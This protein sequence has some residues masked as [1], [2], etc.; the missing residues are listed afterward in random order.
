MVIIIVIKRVCRN[1]KQTFH[2][3]GNEITCRVTNVKRVR[4]AEGT[5]EKRMN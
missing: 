4:L 3:K 2:I 5:L 1:E